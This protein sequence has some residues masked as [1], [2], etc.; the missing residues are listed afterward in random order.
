MIHV[1]Q[2][3]LLSLL[4]CAS[5][6]GSR[7]QVSSDEGDDKAIGLVVDGPELFSTQAVSSG[8]YFG[9]LGCDGLWLQGDWR[10]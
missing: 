8:A 7:L 1:L 4:V 5:P 2:P 3:A 10:T 6:R 9:T